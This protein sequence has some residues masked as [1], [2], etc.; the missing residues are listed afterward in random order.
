MSV[1][2]TFRT[3]LPG[4]IYELALPLSSLPRAPSP[5]AVCT[6]RPGRLHVLNLGHT[7]GAVLRK[8]GDNRGAVVN[9]ITRPLTYLC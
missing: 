5:A 2:D 8:L 4:P 6:V 7:I 3:S 9:V 1:V